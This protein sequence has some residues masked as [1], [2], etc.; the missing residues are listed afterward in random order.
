MGQQQLAALQQRVLLENSRLE[1]VRSSAISTIIARI[2]PTIKKI[3]SRENCSAIFDRTNMVDTGRAKDLT[4][5]VV[6]Q[7]QRDVPPLAPDFLAKIYQRQ[8]P[9]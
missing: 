6:K 5:S 9:Q 1:E 4:D 8:K 7:V 2:A 3:G